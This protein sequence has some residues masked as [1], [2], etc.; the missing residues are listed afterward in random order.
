M[1][2]RGAPTQGAISHSFFGSVLMMRAFV[3]STA[4]CAVV[5]AVGCSETPVAPTQD[6]FTAQFGGAWSG[7]MT[8]SGVNGGEC[9]GADL[10]GQT[11]AGSTPD[12]GS[13]DFSQVNGDLSATVRS[14]TTGLT[15]RY[16]G[17][18]ALASF[19]ATAVSCDGSE[20]LFQCSNGNS[21]ILRLVGSTMTAQQNGGTANGVVAST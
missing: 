20:I 21:R 6:P 2:T 4:L 14:S 16:D 5:A 18:A 1:L 15:C 19:A 17:R 8:L 13:V 11:G 12:Q 3:L 7:S 10:R 9:V